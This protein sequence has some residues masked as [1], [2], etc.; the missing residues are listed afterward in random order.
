M[1]PVV[2][3]WDAEGNDLRLSEELSPGR[4]KKVSTAD[5]DL[6]N[7]RSEDLEQLLA[8]EQ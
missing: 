1:L 7:P 6:M 4:R 8:S 3:L 2:R 5:S